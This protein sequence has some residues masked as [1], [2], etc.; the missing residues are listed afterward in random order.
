MNQYMLDIDLPE[1]LDAEFLA[2]VPAQRAKVNQL[3]G[4]GV[5][6]TYALALDRSKLWVII[7]S[8]SEADAWRV[9]DTFPLAEYMDPKLT[10]LAFYNSRNVALPQLSLN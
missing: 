8:E 2:L 1:Y 3:M 6:A 10:E 4:K 7:L 5:V 9:Y